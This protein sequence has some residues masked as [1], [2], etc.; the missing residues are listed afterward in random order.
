MKVCTS[1]IDEKRRRR[2]DAN[3]API[4][5]NDAGRRHLSAFRQRLD[6]RLEADARRDPKECS[7]TGCDGRS[8][9]RPAGMHRR[10]RS[11]YRSAEPRPMRLIDSCRFDRARELGRFERL[12]PATFVQ[13]EHDHR[14][15]VAELQAV[16]VRVACRLNA[17]G[18][19]RRPSPCRRPLRPTRGESARGTCRRNPS[20]TRTLRSNLRSSCLRRSTYRP[21][22]RRHRR[23]AAPST[24]QTVPL[25]SSTETSISAS[26]VHETRTTQSRTTASCKSFRNALR[27]VVSAFAGEPLERGLRDSRGGCFDLGHVLRPGLAKNAHGRPA[28]AGDVVRN[29]RPPADPRHTPR[30]AAAR[31]S[32]LAGRAASLAD[33]VRCATGTVRCTSARRPRC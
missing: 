28:N 13:V 22:S 30:S 16:D 23:C 32:R 26:P 33:R 2:R 6:D 19:R 4:G 20:G 17:D 14:V 25:G 31:F 12:G 11:R 9:V 8:D 10:D 24:E 1:P 5:G 18:C 21:G 3:I 27:F 15:L 7:P 29:A